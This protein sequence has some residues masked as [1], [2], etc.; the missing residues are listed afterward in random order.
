MNIW[1]VCEHSKE[2]Q[3]NQELRSRVMATQ[4]EPDFDAQHQHKKPGVVA[5]TERFCCGEA[6]A[7]RS[8]ACKS[9]WLLISLKS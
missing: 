7:G 5:N 6:E 4:W 1:D 2:L 9:S 8:L 3:K